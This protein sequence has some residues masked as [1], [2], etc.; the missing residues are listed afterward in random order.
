[1]SVELLKFGVSGFERPANQVRGN[2]FRA[3]LE[4][5]LVKKAQPWRQK[6]DDRS[7]FMLFRGEGRR[8]PRL[9]MVFE[10]ARHLTLV[11]EAG[12]KVLADRPGISRVQAV[13]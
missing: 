5:S 3:S 10:K 13:V 2:A 12:K 7:G 6:R 11:V 8:C 1:M 9:I 4:L